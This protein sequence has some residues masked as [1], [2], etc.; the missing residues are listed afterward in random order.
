VDNGSF[1]YVDTFLWRDINRNIRLTNTGLMLYCMY[2]L[3]KEGNME[4]F[5]FDNTLVD[6]MEAK[7]SW[8][9]GRTAN[10]IGTVMNFV[11]VTGA[12]YYFVG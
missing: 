5:E 1:V 12:V 10:F 3:N 11:M 2:K 9:Q 8:L 6:E 7:T 4:N